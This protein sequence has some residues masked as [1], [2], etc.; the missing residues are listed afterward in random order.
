MN[1][2]LKES[3]SSSV[4]CIFSFYLY[5]FDTQ[6]CSLIFNIPNSPPG[7]LNLSVLERKYR[8]IDE[9][10]PL[11]YR[12][13]YS[14]VEIDSNSG[15]R[16]IFKFELTRYMVFP[17][18][19]VY[20]PTLML[21]L[22]AYGTLW[23]PADDFQDRGTMS[24]TTLLVLISLYNQALNTLPGTSYMKMI[25]YW[26]L[27]CVLFV[28]T[29]IFV[30]LASS[31]VSQVIYMKPLEKKLSMPSNERIIKIAKIVY[32]FTFTLFQVIYWFYLMLNL[33]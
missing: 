20:I 27:V 14:G 6:P 1:I 25:D 5:P 3:F 11:E 13:S 10:V 16:V 30:H 15:R 21:L 33:I 22:I 24:L 8:F 12:L 4:N 31:N 23:I 29:I 9:Q 18:L 26:Y 2:L 7:Y 28:S 17:F 32:G 19:S